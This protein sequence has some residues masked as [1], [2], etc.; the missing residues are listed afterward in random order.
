MHYYSP[1]TGLT[2][3]GERPCGYGGDFGPGIKSLI[4]GL[5]YGCNLSEPSIHSFLTL[6]GAY[7]SKAT[8]S[9]HLTHN[10]DQF[11]EE[12]EEVTYSSVINSISTVR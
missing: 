6:H 8:I 2:Y 9:R 5:K 12:K 7:I 11:H 3:S 4:I 10:L 1:S